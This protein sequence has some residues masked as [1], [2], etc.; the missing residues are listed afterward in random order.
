MNLPLIPMSLSRWAAVAVMA[1]SLARPSNA[2]SLPDKRPALVGSGP[3]SLINLIDTKHLMERGLEHAALFFYCTIQADG[4]TEWFRVFG[5]LDK[6]AVKLQDEVNVKIKQC[7]FIPAVSDHHHVYATFHGLI[8]FTTTGGKPHLRIFSTMDTEELKKES[9]FIDP[10]PFYL[11]G[12]YYDYIKYPAKGFASEDRPGA[13]ELSLTIDASGKLTD[14]RVI[15]ETP[16]GEH[17]GEK[18]LKLIKERTFLP[19]FR[20]GKPVAST[21]RYVLYFVPG[22][23]SLQ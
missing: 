16:T 19:A 4:T 23:W 22:G 10:Q 6:D 2:E 14:T 12:H 9:D 8:A 5:K 20:N 21:T 11:P 3:K 15:K 13:A 7:R 17:F 1:C 18:A